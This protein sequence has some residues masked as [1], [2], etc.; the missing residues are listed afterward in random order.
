[1][2]SK[3]KFPYSCGGKLLEL[4]NLHEMDRGGRGS[5]G[6]GGFSPSWTKVDWICMNWI[7]EG[8]GGL[9][10]QLNQSWLNLHELDRG[11]REGGVFYQL[12]QGWLNLHELDRGGREGGREGGGFSASSPMGCSLMHEVWLAKVTSRH[13]IRVEYLTKRQ[14]RGAFGRF[15]SSWGF[16][17]WIQ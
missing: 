2:Q 3:K 7:G 16:A 4:L 6:C 1:M 14:G 15:A 5:E 11:G 8:V 9:L 17:S 10:C 13:M 12:N